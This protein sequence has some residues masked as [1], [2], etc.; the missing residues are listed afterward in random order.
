MNAA[1]AKFCL[2][3]TSLGDCGIAWRGDMVIATRLPDVEPDLTKRSLA[4]GT[5]GGEGNPSDTIQRAIKAIQLLLDG[6]RKDLSFI[7]CDMKHAK[8]FALRVYDVARAIPVGK[9]MTYGIIAEQLGDKQLSQ[10]VGQIL[11]RNPL[12]IIVPC[13][14][15][16]GAN[17]KLTGFSATGGIKTKLKMLEI[18]GAA[19]GKSG[20]L[21][22]DLPLAVK[23]C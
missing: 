5:G 2:F 15:V 17:G 13:H 22:S 12:P 11:G 20:G 1:Q 16:L 8:P 18:E 23:P 6:E 4:R 21:F 14:R 7:H 9:T 3:S 19:I 10:K